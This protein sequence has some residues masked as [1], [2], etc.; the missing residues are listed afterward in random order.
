MMHVGLCLV[1]LRLPENGSL[2]EKRAILR[3]L[4]E[5]VRRRFNVAVAE[6]EELD[7]WHSAALGLACVSNDARHANSVLS[8]AVAFIEEQGRDAEFLG[9]ELE[10]ISAF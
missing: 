4:T 9:Y 6:V 8:Q 10:L 3:P 7:N 5:R 2:K 1:R